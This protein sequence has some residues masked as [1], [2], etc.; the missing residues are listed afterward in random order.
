MIN[1]NRQ[2]ASP[3]GGGSELNCGSF[4]AWPAAKTACKKLGDGTAPSAK[5]ELWVLILLSATALRAE[6]RFHFMQVD[7][8]II[9]YKQA[10]VH[11]LLGQRAVQPAPVDEAAAARAHSAQRA[12]AA[13]AARRRQFAEVEPVARM[14]LH[15]RA[16]ADASTS[17]AREDDD[18]NDPYLRAAVSATGLQLQA[19]QRFGAQGEGA[20][21]GRWFEYRVSDLGEHRRFRF[22]RLQCNTG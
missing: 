11:G 3:G 17:G 1:Y 6:Q 10:D 12:A 9:D 4:E 7:M 22:S 2:A 20:I 19:A 18:T 15:T 8:P 16:R 21:A 14:G 13:E 5:R